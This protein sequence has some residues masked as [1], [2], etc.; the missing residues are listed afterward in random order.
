MLLLAVGCATPPPRST[1]PSP[2]GSI[3]SAR[4]APP[5][6]AAGAGGPSAEEWQNARQVAIP[7]AEALGCEASELAEWIRLV[8]RGPSFFA[9][10][11]SG[12]TLHTPHSAESAFAT[13]S[14]G[15]VS[16][17]ARFREGTNISASFV[18]DTAIFRLSASWPEGAARPVPF[19]RFI[20][21]PERSAEAILRAAC[22]CEPRTLPDTGVDAFGCRPGEATME[23][24]SGWPPSCIRHLTGSGGCDEM[25][26]CLT[27]EPNHFNVCGE[28]EILTGGHP[29][30]QCE[31]ECSAS[32][33]CPDGFDCKASTVMGE[34][35]LVPGPTVCGT[36]D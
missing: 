30:T 13:V 11:P 10:R 3:P 21:A 2:V 33:P 16:V 29:F 27:S 26:V 17:V 5:F 25:N 12:V 6:A 1:S 7:G 22:A 15:V 31:T 28:G 19:G 9:A 20:G 35:T 23:A 8:C 4:P 34:D 24:G 32:L 36:R 18:W 14:D